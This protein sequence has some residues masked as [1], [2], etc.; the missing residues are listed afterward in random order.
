MRLRHTGL[1]LGSLIALVVGAVAVAVHGA[2]PA[3]AAPMPAS[4]LHVVG[5]HLVDA[6]G[7]TVVLWGVNRSGGEYS[8]VPHGAANAR[9][10][11]SSFFDGPMDASAVASIASWAGVNTVRVPLNSDC[12]LSHSNIPAAFAGTA[13]LNAVQ[14]YVSILHQHGL[15]AELDL[16]W[17]DGLY[18]NMLGACTSDATPVNAVCQ[19]PMPDA[20]SAIPFWTTIANAFK[21]D[22]ATI[23]DVFNEPF[24]D[25][26]LA[27]GTPS[28]TCWR[29]GG[30]ACGNLLRDSSGNNVP[31]AGMQAM[32][33][34]IRGTGARNVIALGG[35]AFSND[36]SMW[37]QFEPTDSAGNLV[38]A[39]HSYNFNTCSNSTC[40]NANIAPLATRVP[41]IAG[42]I[43][44]NDC[45]HGYIDG[46]MAFMDSNHVSY[47]G[48]AWNADFQ[49][50][51]GPSLIT[52]Y[53]GTPTAFGIGLKNNIAKFG[54]GG[55][56]PTPTASGTP[57]PTPT[58]T[59]TPTPTP[60]PTRT[61]TPTPTPVSGNGGVTPTTVLAANGP[62][63][64][65]EQVHLA[66]TAPLTALTVTI[67]IQVTPGV[68]FS[69]QYNTIGGSILQ[70]HSST[71]SAL[72]YTYTLGSG[73][74]LGPNTGWTFAAQAGGNGTAH[75][76]TG[77]TFAVT[78]TTG[79][80]SFSQTG[81]F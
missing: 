56:S 64:N 11:P 53:D 66:N 34:A 71:A 9:S 38:A 14:A 29:D 5:N 60:T 31:A 39:W 10:V 57:T 43:G 45:A 62:F 35:L 30:T 58:P 55:P 18:N 47:L 70:S 44:E 49:C 26:L 36:D 61:P 63:F 7:T 50:N 8:C 81:H 72:T 80:A 41:V 51:N 69:G 77:D 12:L 73:Q 74:T 76:T 48:W 54:N 4:G 22:T 68:T 23:F 6:N 32:V 40:W 67:V 65:D 59:R 78:Y 16:H 37:S 42:E 21:G 17:T 52:A 33:N 27:S 3:A 28:W 2:T 25:F 20:A 79:G 1:V 46:L 24:P 19:K 13:Y 15:V 75:P